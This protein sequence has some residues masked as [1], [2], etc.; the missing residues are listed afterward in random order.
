MNNHSAIKQN[1]TLLFDPNREP[2]LIFEATS[3]REKAAA[4]HAF[5]VYYQFVDWAF[6]LERD[7]YMDSHQRLSYC[8]GADAGDICARIQVG[9]LKVRTSLVGWI[10]LRFLSILTDPARAQMRRRPL[11]GSLVLTDQGFVL[12]QID[13]Y[14]YQGQQQPDNA[15]D[16]SEAVSAVFGPPKQEGVDTKSQDNTLRTSYVEVDIS[17]EGDQLAEASMLVQTY[18]FAHQII[19]PQE[20]TA[21]IPIRR[22]SGSATDPMDDGC[23]L[24]L[25]L[26]DDEDIYGRPLAWGWIAIAMEALIWNL[27]HRGTWQEFQA[28]IKAIG[29]TTAF[30]KVTSEKVDRLTDG[31]PLPSQ[32]NLSNAPP[33]QPKVKVID[34]GSG[35]GAGANMSTTENVETSR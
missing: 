28:T 3:E 16:A 14:L 2:Q 23:M 12:A 8:H 33:V 10:G 13:P 22:G 19:W 30:L 11:Q 34:G 15:L 24:V 32:E 7:L 29:S 1:L 17:F 26:L 18:Q 21:S 25:D 4:S 20:V 31:S 9:D 5:V 6:F 35:N 27:A